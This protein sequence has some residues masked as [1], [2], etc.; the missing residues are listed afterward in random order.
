MSKPEVIAEN[1]IFR[2]EKLEL[3]PFGTN[4]YIVICRATGES[5][6]VDA[7]A[8]AGAILERLKETSPRYILLTHGHPDHT[9]ALAEVHAALAVPLAA[10]PADSGTLPVKPDLALIDGD[11]VECGRLKLAVLHTPGHTPGSLCFRAGRMI[12]AGD[13]I[14][15]GG[16]G[17]T[18]SPA[19][20]EQI[21]RSITAK[22]FTLPDDT[23]LFPGHGGPTT[24]G[25][26][27][28]LYRAFASCPRDPGLCGD[29]TWQ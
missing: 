15:P 18:W 26:E 6:L 20:L 11:T 13:T 12:L 9:G 17:K 14:F 16:P 27:K 10:H 7:P 1:E 3:G 19:G 21:I 28:E 23:P 25:K 22:I 4:A 2:A 29:V 24:A 5:V 8:D